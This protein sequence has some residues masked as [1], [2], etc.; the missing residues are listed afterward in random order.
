MLTLAATAARIDPRHA[1]SAH[2]RERRRAAVHP[3]R[4]HVTADARRRAAAFRHLRRRVVRATRA[5]VRHPRETD[6][7]LRQRA[8]LLVDE[9]DA[10]AN[11]LDRARMQV[12]PL[13]PLCDDARHHRRRELRE[14]RQ[15]PVAVRAHPLTLFVELADDARADVVAP[16]VELLLQL[17]LDD[18]PLLLDHQ[19]LGEALG[20][21][22][23]ALGL[24]RP[25]HR[26]LEQA[27]AD[28]GGLLLV[29]AEIVERLA[30]VEIAL[31]AGDDAEPRLRAVDDQLVEPVHAA[32]VQRRVDL[33][34]LHPRFGSEERIGPA[35][36]HAVGRQR[37]IVGDDDFDVARV[38][39]DRR[40]A[41]DGV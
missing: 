39:V 7:R 25:G 41:F 5:E 8:L 40:R 11:L 33:V 37:E 32:V 2:V 38:T 10:L 30:N 35:D 23:H 13:D 16:V 3:D 14:R 1:F 27:D 15:Q 17:V 36:R 26:D 18:L 29:D 4:H 20:E 9:V 21:V 6:R 22:A 19:D 28:L 31:A 12:E 24:E 34:V